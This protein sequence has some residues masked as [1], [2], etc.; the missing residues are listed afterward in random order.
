MKLGEANRYVSYVPCMYVP[1]A[2]VMCRYQELGQ[3]CQPQEKL[4]PEVAPA[5]MLPGAP[6]SQNLLEGK[7]LIA[8]LI[9]LL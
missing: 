7:C 5:T 6:C 4:G 2:K 9:L 1:C 8:K 3:S